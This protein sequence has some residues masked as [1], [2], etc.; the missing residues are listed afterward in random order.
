MKESEF[1]YLNQQHN[2]VT[3]TE[4]ETKHFETIKER[5]KKAIIEA[6]VESECCMSDAAKLLGISRPGLYVKIKD[7]SLSC[8]LPRNEK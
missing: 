8:W 7:Y 5:E 2:N 4:A 3:I 1:I 6:L